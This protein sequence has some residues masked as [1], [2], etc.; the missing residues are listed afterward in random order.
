MIS[1]SLS[2]SHNRSLSSPK[3]TT[4]RASD[5]ELSSV[6]RWAVVCQEVRIKRRKEAWGVEEQ[7]KA[8]GGDEGLPSRKEVAAM[9][10]AAATEETSSSAATPANE[11]AVEE[12]LT[13][14]V[15]AGGGVMAVEGVS[16]SGG[17]AAVGDLGDS[18]VV[19]GEG[20]ELAT[21][22][23]DALGGRGD[24]TSSG[25]GATGTPHT[26]TVEDLLAA[27]KR[28]GNERREGAGD[29][30]VTAGRVVATPVLRATVVESMVGDSG[31]G[32]S[33]P[34]PFTKGDFLDIARPQDILDALGLDAGVREV[35]RGARA[36]EDQTS[37]LLL[38]ALLSGAGMT[39][40]DMGSPEMD[41]LGAEGPKEEVA[42][43]E[44]VT[45]ADEAKAYL[46]SARPGFVSETYAPLLHLFEPTGMTGYVPAWTDYPEDL[47]LRDRATHI[48][49]GWMTRTK[50]IYGHGGSAN[51]LKYFKELPRRVR[52]LVEEAGFGPFIQLLT[53]VR[54]DR[55]VL[56]ALM[57]GAVVGYHQHVPLPLRGDDALRWFLGRVPR[58]SGGVAEYG[59][60]T[61]YWDHEPANDVEAAQ[62]TR[63][64][65]LYLFGA[66]LF[67]LRRSRVHLS[68][69]AGLVDLKQAGLFDWGGAAL[70][71]L[72]CFLGAAS[73]GVGDTIGGY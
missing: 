34:V 5:L 47:L 51:S 21:S 26:P 1:L 60:F 53:A 69:L 7:G 9:A 36:T 15:E 13:T 35:L 61:T 67:P 56:T 41:D 65:L 37:V 3:T 12:D 57:D 10:A 32:A 71:M 45:A 66:S 2:H 63:A 31:I 18:E 44:R 11:R 27:A 24:G 52:E 33:H 48:S 39:A 68:Y 49:S 72:Y 64:Y 43:E 22:S 42:V 16:A 46:A 38:G 55:A 8:S 23:R 50:D 59:Q 70:C 73:R 6:F 29:E 17:V 28:A 54:V 25:G 62:M 4:D 40:A 30:V 14:R 19:R 20:E 58:R